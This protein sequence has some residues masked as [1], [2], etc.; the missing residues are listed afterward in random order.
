MRRYRIDPQRAGRLV[1]LHTAFLAERYGPVTEKDDRRRRRDDARKELV[2][3]IAQLY[4]E[5]CPLA[6]IGDV[7]GITKQGVHALIAADERLRVGT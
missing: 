3:L 7:L 2:D 1:R 5:G 4:Y 6:R